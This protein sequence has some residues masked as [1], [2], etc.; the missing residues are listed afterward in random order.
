[1]FYRESNNHRMIG[2]DTVW[3][4]HRDVTVS[5][6]L[7]RV[8]QSQNDRRRQ[9]YDNNGRL[10]ALQTTSATHG[11]EKVGYG[12]ICIFQQLK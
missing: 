3:Y 7:Q 8:K 9:L 12:V 2:E 11:D 1:L 6:V 10:T 4:L 5:V